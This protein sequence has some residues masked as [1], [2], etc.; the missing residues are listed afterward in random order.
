MPILVQQQVQNAKEHWNDL[1]DANRI[2]VCT[3]VEDRVMIGGKCERQ[4]GNKYDIFDS[5]AVEKTAIKIEVSQTVLKQTILLNDVCIIP[6]ACIDTIAR[7]WNQH[8]INHIVMFDDLPIKVLRTSYNK[9]SALL[10]N[11]ATENKSLIDICGDGS[12]Q[13]TG[14][15]CV[16]IIAQ[17]SNMIN[18]ATTSIR[19]WND[20]IVTTAA[21]CVQL[22]LDKLQ[23]NAM[24]EAVVCA[25][26]AC[27]LV[28]TQTTIGTPAFTNS[29]WAHVANAK[30]KL[31]IALKLATNEAASK[32]EWHAGCC[33][34][35]QIRNCTTTITWNIGYGRN[36]VPYI[37]SDECELF[38]L[39]K[40]PV[41]VHLERLESNI[42]QRFDELAIAVSSKVVHTDG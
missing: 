38:E 30:Q 17:M 21:T 27:A 9:V 11:T 41:L 5:R 33:T 24:C 12:I 25:Q 8:E 26:L 16:Q 32:V 18:V 7:E 22:V 13:M 23:S 4:R 36:E 2:G 20:S 42:M 10:N 15:E 39:S 40:D 37:T 1:L 19:D 35:E 28:N 6:Y 3:G 14:V 31:A 29:A 34:I